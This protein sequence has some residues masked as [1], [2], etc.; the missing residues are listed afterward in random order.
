VGAITS[1]IFDG[2]PRISQ[3][4]SIFDT[5]RSTRGASLTRS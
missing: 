3:D 5:S 2:P 4:M 1:G